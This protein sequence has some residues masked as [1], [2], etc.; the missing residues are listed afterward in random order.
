MMFRLLKNAFLSQKFFTFRHFYLCTSGKTLPQVLMNI[1]RQRKIT[2]PPGRVFSK[3]SSSPVERKGGTMNS[4]FF[5]MRSLILPKAGNEKLKNKIFFSCCRYQKKK[6]K[7]ITKKNVLIKKIHERE[8]RC[9][10]LEK[11]FLL[12]LECQQY[13][14]CL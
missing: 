5:Q 3:I 7:R 12:L 2:H 10:E 4:A 8:V 6:L 14:F 1:P 11:G 9:A 13:S